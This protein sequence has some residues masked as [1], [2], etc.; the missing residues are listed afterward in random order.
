ML[1]REEDFKNK[2][3]SKKKGFHIT[4]MSPESNV[5][6]EF[7]R[8][9]ASPF[10]SSK[11]THTYVSAKSPSY[12]S[13][14]SLKKSSKL[15]KSDCVSQPIFRNMIHSSNHSYMQLLDTV[16][17]STK[18]IILQYVTYPRMHFVHCNFFCPLPHDCKVFQGN[19]ANIH[20]GMQ[21]QPQ[22]EDI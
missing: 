11:I 13:Q 8:C 21:S 7:F 22:L 19:Y 12:Q 18:L 6:K 20:Y 4:K 2:I 5:P 15:P 14:R 9:L 1:H 10:L 3:C 17:L 16:K